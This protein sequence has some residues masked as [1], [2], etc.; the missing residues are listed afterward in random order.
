MAAR[1]VTLVVALVVASVGAA[2]V[3]L[4]ALQADRRAEA[5]FADVRVV[6]ANDFIRQGT[7]LG[8]VVGEAGADG[9]TSLT[10]QSVS[11]S[12]L[13]PEAW[14]GDIPDGR[15][16]LAF[17][18]DVYPGDQISDAKLGPVTG[19]GDLL[20]L[21]PDPAAEAGTAA[22]RGRAAMVLALPDNQRGSSWL[23]AGSTVAVLM[24]EPAPP[25]G[26]PRTCV[27]VPD[28]QIIAVGSQ[29]DSGVG[30]GVPPETADGAGAGA[31]EVPPG[32]VVVEVD[33]TRALELTRAQDGGS[34]YFVLR[35]DEGG[36]DFTRRCYTD[37]E[38]NNLFVSSGGVTG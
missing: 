16:D 35:P 11:E 32:F 3:I 2:L 5:Q 28:A 22:A 1:I 7:V 23:R 6:V 12:A 24:D 26:R 27:L 17:L 19:G 25:E 38:L 14:V 10:L 33:Q 8:D 20:G 34:L 37:D 36:P 29:T 18:T 15:Q 21:S 9:E 13:I 4:Y 31:A 30:A